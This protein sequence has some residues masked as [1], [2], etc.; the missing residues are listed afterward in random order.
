[1]IVSLDPAYGY[2][3]NSSKTWLLVK[4]EHLPKAISI[5]EGSNIQITD[6]GRQYLGSALRCATFTWDIS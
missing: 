5:F 1:M 3:T 2:Y 6:K 4:E